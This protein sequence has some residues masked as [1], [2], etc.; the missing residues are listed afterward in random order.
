MTKLIRS[1]I[2]FAL[3]ATPLFASKTTTITIENPVVV[4]ARQLAAGDYKVAYKGSGSTVK[5]TMALHGETP[6]I[7]QATFVAGQKGNGEVLVGTVNGV[8]VLQEIDLAS[9]AL[10][11]NIP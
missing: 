6:V 5:V 2:V 9:G 8:R 7:L 4:G 1:A 11:F 10:V 3:I